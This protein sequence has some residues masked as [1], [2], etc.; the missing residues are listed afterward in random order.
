MSEVIANN[1][2]IDQANG[3]IAIWHDESHINAY[4]A[5]YK[6]YKVL[7]PGYIVPQKR[8]TDF[9]FKPYMVVLDKVNV[10]GHEFL[11]G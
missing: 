6:K 8:L 10:G 7:H 1:I 5:K 4:F 9:P 2:D 11:R 3:I